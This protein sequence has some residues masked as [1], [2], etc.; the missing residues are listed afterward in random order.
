LIVEEGNAI[1]TAYLRLDLLPAETQPALRE[2]FRKYVDSR[3]EVY[4]RLPDL[5]AA[6]QELARSQELQNEI[7][8]HEID[9]CQAASNPAVMTLVMPST[10]DMIDNTST[11]TVAALSH[12]PQI[13]FAMIFLLVLASALVA[14]Q[15]LA[16][17]NRRDLLQRV[18]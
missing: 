3:R 15:D 10:N 5:A 11:R 6:Q 2:M 4:R 16:S 7:W 14:G 1:G 13:I 9:A 8:P 18:H 17:A 12:P